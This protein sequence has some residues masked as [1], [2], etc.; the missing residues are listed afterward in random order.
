M[1]LLMDKFTN[2]SE[3]MQVIFDFDDEEVAQ[4]VAEIGPRF[5]RRVRCG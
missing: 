4:Q 1:M 3:F 2:I 5:W